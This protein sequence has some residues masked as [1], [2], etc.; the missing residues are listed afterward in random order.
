MLRLRRP[1]KEVLPVNRGGWSVAWHVQTRVAMRGEDAR[2]IEFRLLPNRAAER[3]SPERAQAR[4]K[5]TD[6]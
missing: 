1:V 6:S 2:N 4:V 3:A 5:N